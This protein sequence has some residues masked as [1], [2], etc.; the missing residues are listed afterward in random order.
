MHSVGLE[1][2]LKKY[3]SDTNHSLRTDTTAP[4]FTKDL[5]RF[6][7]EVREANAEFHT[8]Q[9]ASIWPS[10]SRILQPFDSLGVAT[11]SAISLTPF[12]PAGLIL[13]ATLHLVK[14]ANQAIDAYSGI[15]DVLSDIAGVMDCLTIHGE[16]RTI[17]PEAREVIENMMGVI[18]EIL[19]LASKVIGDTKKKR[20]IA[21]QYILPPLL[22]KGTPIEMKMEAL[23]KMQQHQNSLSVVVMGNGLQD[24]ASKLNEDEQEKRLDKILQG[25]LLDTMKRIHYRIT[26][27]AKDGI[28][29]DWVADEPE[30][31]RW[32][33][34][35]QRGSKSAMIWLKSEQ[36]TGKTYAASHLIRRLYKED[37]SITTY[38]Y[39]QR[40]EKGDYLAS[41]ILASIALQLLKKSEGFRKLAIE[42]LSD[43]KLEL[44]ADTLWKKLF[45]PFSKSHRRWRTFIVIDGLDAAPPLEQDILLSKLKSLQTSNFKGRHLFHVAIFARPTLSL[46]HNIWTAKRSVF[47]IPE[48]K[49]RKDVAKFIDSKLKRIPLFGELT[50]DVQNETIDHLRKDINTDFSLAELVVTEAQAYTTP[51]QLL[52]FLKLPVSQDIAHHVREILELVDATIYTK[53]NW[54]ATLQWIACAYRMLTVNE[55]L[56]V[57]HADLN[58]NTLKLPEEVPSK[59]LEIENQRIFTFTSEFSVSPTESTL[60]ELSNGFVRDYLV[61]EDHIRLSDFDSEYAVHK[62]SAHAAIAE[63][64]LQRL[65]KDEPKHARATN[66]DI[67][68]YAADYVI[69]HFRAVR[70]DAVLESR[71]KRG[72]ARQ[73]RQL[74]ETP[75][76]IRRWYNSISK[77]RLLDIIKLLLADDEVLERIKQW[78]HPESNISPRTLYATFARFCKQEW[79]QGSNMNTEFEIL[80]LYRYN[81]LEDLPSSVRTDRLPTGIAGLSSD[82]VMYLASNAVSEGDTEPTQNSNWHVRV[83]TVLMD[84]KHVNEA[85]VHFSNAEAKDPAN[86][87][88]KNGL[89]LAF[90]ADGDT[91]NAIKKA[92]EALECDP[93]PDTTCQ[94]NIYFNL[95]G[96]QMVRGRSSD[97]INS[98]KQAHELDPLDFEKMA[99]YFSALGRARKWN[100]LWKLCENLHSSKSRPSDL[101][102]LLLGWE[103]GHDMFTQM[104]GTDENCRRFPEKVFHSLV[105]TA[106]QE[107]DVP[108]SVWEEFQRGLFFS[109]HAPSGEEHLRIW[110]ALSP[111]PESEGT[112]R[113]AQQLQCRGL[114]DVYYQNAVQSKS[115]RDTQKWV[116]KLETL[117]GVPSGSSTPNRNMEDRAEAAMM[118][119]RWRRKRES[120]KRNEFKPLFRPQICQG[121][122]ILEDDDPL[123]DSD[124]YAIL[125]RALL[126]AGDQADALRVFAAGLLP[127][128]TRIQ[129]T[130]E[131][132]D[133]IDSQVR[134]T[135]ESV[136]IPF[137]CH[138]QLGCEPDKWLAFYVCRDCLDKSYCVTCLT[139]SSKRVCDPSHGMVQVYLKGRVTGEPMAKLRGSLLEVDKKWLKRLKEKWDITDDTKPT[140]SFPTPNIILNSQQRRKSVR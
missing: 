19:G 44:N 21:K 12:A 23:K 93:K 71:K 32:I 64:C 53:Q 106:K 110:E 96:W 98:A 91:R 111:Q 118:L 49:I 60:V 84:A 107:D 74:L 52:S 125:A 2:S 29:A 4:N 73:I 139:G 87:M 38:F 133:A 27:S 22:S 130:E 43:T 97:A 14:V 65:L 69:D 116:A 120:V 132:N 127:L 6:K 104:A 85:R 36:G 67:I 140:S 115:K 45:E 9:G 30:V 126:L 124:G 100:T 138:G 88:A 89:A 103:E 123:N 79:T 33:S 63:V 109:R 16:A 34:L 122:Q 11:S 113:Y 37:R 83:A 86:W 51:T 1:Q 105:Q 8:Q 59:D 10:I 119:G 92:S 82:E 24:L 25:E 68:A 58:D 57:R 99:T 61:Q 18:I 35:Q 135:I 117:A 129:W 26:S 108:G 137:H 39:V 75:S 70:R 17:R 134:Q 131:N 31:Q 76:A 15:G 3:E 5:E 80:F 7:A 28:N 47:P 78:E 101:V 54:K 20:H 40:H 95:Y 13:G 128:R 46:R 94:S 136:P 41:S 121:I 55:V 50:T 114:S 66:P 42:V 56:F 90:A 112:D 48:D 81:R 62:S 72:L 77:G 102:K